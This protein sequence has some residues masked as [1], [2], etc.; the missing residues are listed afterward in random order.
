L[1]FKQNEDSKRTNM[2]PNQ[3][4]S[5]YSHH[6]EGRVDPILPYKKTWFLLHKMWLKLAKPHQNLNFSIFWLFRSKNVSNMFHDLKNLRI[7]QR[8]LKICQFRPILAS[9]SYIL[10][11]LI[12]FWKKLV[13]GAPITYFQFD[14][15]WSYMLWGI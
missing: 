12:T 11:I 10:W 6:S 8:S 15:F 2:K 13:E 1:Q 9:F 7:A 14:I 5:K 4:H 3:V